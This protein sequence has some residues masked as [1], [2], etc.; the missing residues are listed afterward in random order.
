MRGNGEKLGRN[1]I[2][3]LV[4]KTRHYLTPLMKSW[5]LISFLFLLALISGIFPGV[6]QVYAGKQN[7]CLT[8]LYTGDERGTIQPCG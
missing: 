8:L 1:I 3:N 5:V 7:A 2:K 6:F 4:Y